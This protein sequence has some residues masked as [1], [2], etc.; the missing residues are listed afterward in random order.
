[1]AVIPEGGGDGVGLAGENNNA[2]ATAAH[3]DAAVAPPNYA[4]LLFCC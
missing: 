2:V 3:P 4:T 1:M